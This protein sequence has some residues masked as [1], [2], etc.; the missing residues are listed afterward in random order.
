MKTTPAEEFKRQVHEEL[1][2]RAAQLRATLDFVSAGARPQGTAEDIVLAGR[3]AQLTVF[4]QADPPGLP[5]TVLVTLQIARFGMGGVTSFRAEKGIV[6]DAS[7]LVREA[8]LRELEE[9]G[10]QSE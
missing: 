4:R 9:S 8:T 1:E 7:G 5:D 10:Q 6:F 2:R 3:E